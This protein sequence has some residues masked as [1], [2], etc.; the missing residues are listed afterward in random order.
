[1]NRLLLDRQPGS[2][3][4]QAPALPAPAL[5]AS[6]LPASALPVAAA[7]CHGWFGSLDSPAAGTPFAFAAEA[8]R[9]R[10][11]FS[12]NAMLMN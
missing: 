12:D 8:I 9:S 10:V 7:P 1:M 5:P 4:L 11:S 6:A 3:T 2:S